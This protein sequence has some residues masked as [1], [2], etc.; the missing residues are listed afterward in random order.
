MTSCAENVDFRAPSLLVAEPLLRGQAKALW[1]KE[2][3]TS[4]FLTKD[5]RMGQVSATHPGQT[6]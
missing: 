2:I 6:G 4:R 5:V 1:Q 3:E